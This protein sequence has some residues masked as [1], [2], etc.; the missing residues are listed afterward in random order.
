MNSESYLNCNKKNNN[1]K[2][3]KG[4]MLSY[5]IYLYDNRSKLFGSHFPTLALLLLKR[6]KGIYA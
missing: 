4:Y 2:K 3:Y 6:E 5:R 1:N